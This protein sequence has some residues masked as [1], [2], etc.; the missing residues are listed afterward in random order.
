MEIIRFF[1]GNF[2]HFIALLIILGGLLNLILSMWIKL[3]NYL[4]IRKHGYPPSHCN[5]S[6]EMRCSIIDKNE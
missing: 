3:L 5:C 4:T 1:F 6:G 2:W